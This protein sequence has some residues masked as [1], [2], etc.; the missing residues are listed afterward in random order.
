MSGAAL[1]RVFREA[2]GRIIAALAARFRNV[3]LAEDACAEACARALEEWPATTVPNDPAAWLYRV[4]FRVALDV[5]RHQKTQHR[6]APLLADTDHPLGPEDPD[7]D[8]I[9]EERLRLIFI[10][11]HPAVNVEA[12]AALTLRLVC[13]L[14]TREIARAFLVSE[15]TLAQRLTRAKQKIADAGIPFEVPGPESWPERLNSV[16]STLEVAYAKA[17]ED[18]AGTSAH[19]HYAAEILHLT[20]V[21]VQLIPDE[22]DSNALAAL[23]RFSEAR[24]PAR[25]NSSGQMVPLSAQDPARWNRDLIDEGAAYLERAIAIRPESSRVIK[26]QIHAC[27][28]R[29][30]SLAE[31][32]PWP[33]ILALYDRLIAIDDNPIARLNRAVAMAEVRGADSALAEIERLNSAQLGQYAPYHAVRAD[34]LRRVG[35]LEKALSAYD[36]AIA[37]VATRAE[38]AWL[39]EQ[40][41][42]LAR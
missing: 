32:A 19:A 36:A 4:A 17:H 11:C 25:L 34:L 37:L 39:E 2:S 35:R 42:G 29:R 15:V 16:L 5:I 8:V 22:S 33:D 10:C 9:P 31:P 7:F 41:K 6:F 24:R 40:R 28:C 26:A 23:V 12:R 38:R 21:V 20:R 3:A 18:A 30:A 14:T 27:W 13:G 1:D